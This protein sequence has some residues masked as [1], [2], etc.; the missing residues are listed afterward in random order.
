[1]NRVERLFSMADYNGMTER[2]ESLSRKWGWFLAFGIAL[3]VLGLIAVNYAITATFVSVMFLGTVMMFAGGI[4]LVEAFTAGKW[5]MFFVHILISILYLVFG[6]VIFRQP[7]ATAAVVTLLMAAFFFT[8]GIFRII[9]AISMQ[10]PQWGWLL[11]SGIVSVLLG[12]LVTA[13]WPASAL[14]ILGVYIGV[15]MIV[16]GWTLVV[17]SMAIKNIGQDVHHGIGQAA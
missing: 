7:A 2:A 17:A 4:H 1:M 9:S 8:A 6:F 14:W 11:F 12:I 16:T 10:M 3:I 15:D 13:S 5:N